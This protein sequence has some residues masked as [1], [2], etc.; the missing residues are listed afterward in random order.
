MFEHPCEIVIS[1][2]LQSNFTEITLPHG[3]SPVK[4]L[5]IFRTSFPRTPLKYCFYTFKV[6]NEDS[7]LIFQRP[8]FTSYK[9]QSIN[10]QSKLFKVRARVLY[11]Y[12][13]HCFLFYQLE[14]LKFLYFLVPYFFPVGHCWI[15]SRSCLKT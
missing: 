13:E 4:L 14:M 15:N 2:K 11:F 1:L 12:S 5:H 9:T 7:K 10:L 6:I 3:C 8:L